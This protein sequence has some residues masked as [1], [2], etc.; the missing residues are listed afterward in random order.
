MTALSLWRFARDPVQTLPP[1]VAISAGGSSAHRANTVENTLTPRFLPPPKPLPTGPPQR[2][3][4]I[5][6]CLP[7]RQNDSH[8]L[9]IGYRAHPVATAYQAPDPNRHPD[10][11][12]EIGWRWPGEYCPETHWFGI[13]A[14]NF[15]PS[16]PVLP[17]YSP[18]I[19][20]QR[21]L[22]APHATPQTEMGHAQDGPIGY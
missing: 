14:A 11:P 6:A 12:Q 20:W 7:A 4:S 1:A 17:E 19:E 5:G 22:R 10:N 2:G 21:P 18:L 9:P 8:F 16:P 3:R 13:C 15:D